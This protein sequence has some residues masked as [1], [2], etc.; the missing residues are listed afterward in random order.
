MKK[1]LLLTASLLVPMVLQAAPPEDGKGKG[2]RGQRSV[3]AEVL[4]KFDTD[5]DGKLSKEERKAAHEAR[6]AERIAK[7]DTDG[8]G[9]LSDAEKQAARDARKA[10]MLEKFDAD[11]D[12]ELSKEERKAARDEMGGRPP[13]GGKGP[14]KGE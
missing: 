4:E 2:P 10:E 12:G 8:D 14:K 1:T 9:E 7:Y 6:K 3:P 11:G 5:G 13:R